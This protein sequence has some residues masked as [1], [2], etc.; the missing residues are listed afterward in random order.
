MV[1]VTYGVARNAARVRKTKTK[2]KTSKQAPG[3]F[4][5]LMVAMMDARLKQAHRELELHRH[6]FTEGDEPFRWR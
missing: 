6:L 4:A 3:F 2:T 5:R 1:A